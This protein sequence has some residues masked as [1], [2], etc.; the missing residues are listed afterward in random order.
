MRIEIHTGSL[1]EVRQ[2]MIDFSSSCLPPSVEKRPMRLRL[3]IEIE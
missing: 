3:E 1:V 2:S